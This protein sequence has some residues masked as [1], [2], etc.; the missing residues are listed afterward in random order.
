MNFHRYAEY[1]VFEK[2][3]TIEADSRNKRRPVEKPWSEVNLVVVD[4][5]PVTKQF[6]L[7]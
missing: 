5:T 3:I 1:E 2:V 6:L 4:T 7:P